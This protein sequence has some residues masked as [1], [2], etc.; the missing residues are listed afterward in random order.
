M[1]SDFH[2]HTLVSDGTLDPAALLQ[3]A[4][5]CGI[6]HLSIT[7]HDALGAYSWEGGRVRAEAARLGL[8]LT[9][10]IEMDADLDGL[11]V[12]LLG[13]GL[14][15][16]DPALGAH[17]ERVR[18]A[19]WERARR[20]LEIVGGLLGADAITEREVF[21][22]GR[23]TLM[24]PHFI[25][26]LLDKGLFAT[27]EEAN[28]WFKQNVK[29]GV[30]VAKPPLAEAIALIQG[31]G[32]WTALAHPG[33]YQRDGYPVAERLPVLRGQGLDGV[34]LD[35]PYHACSPHQWTAEQ[36]RAFIAEVRAAAEPLGMRL[37][38]GSD[39]HTPEDF[40]RVYLP[41]S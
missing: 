24:K 19:R 38:R 37:T 18:E 28:R 2:L 22:P 34:E 25:H 15:L 13:F 30:A 35:Y 4:A 3:R 1:V 36:E 39:S 12:H 31:A 14:R 21:A 29:T 5:A 32:G 40:D 17:L 7:D 27:Y 10:G 26:P 20:E 23:Q 16:D 9:V 6:T 11:E 41:S 33:Y 8:D